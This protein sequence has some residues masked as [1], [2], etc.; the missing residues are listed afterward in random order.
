MCFWKIALVKKVGKHYYRNCAL[1]MLCYVSCA[2][3]L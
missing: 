2:E 1:H 3:N